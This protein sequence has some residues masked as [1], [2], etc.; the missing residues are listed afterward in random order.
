MISGD[1]LGPPLISA[2]VGVDRLPLSDLP[3]FGVSA[4]GQLLRVEGSRRIILMCL[5]KDGGVP[6]PQILSYPGVAAHRPVL[7]IILL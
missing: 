6:R 2:A 3:F 1:D 5:R 4:G 7:R